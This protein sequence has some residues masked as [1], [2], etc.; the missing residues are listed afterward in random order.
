M[1]CLVKKES[2]STVSFNKK[3]F[4]KNVFALVIPMAI[5]NLINVGVLAADVFMLGKVGENSLSGASLAGQIYYVMTLFLFGLTS[6]ATVLTS[7]YWGKRDITTIEKI[8]AL[9]MKS[10][11]LVTSIFAVHSRA[12]P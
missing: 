5:Q 2:S 7:Q 12:R 11:V 10:A 6:G 3:E 1:N 9:G 8:L 4:Y